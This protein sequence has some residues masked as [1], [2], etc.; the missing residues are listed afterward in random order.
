M[1]RSAPMT[2]AALCEEKL[3]GAGSCAPRSGASGGR[4]PLYQTLAA[5]RNRPL[6]RIP[7]RMLS[8]SRTRLTG[9]ATSSM[10]C[11]MAKPRP[12]WP[13]ADR[14]ARKSAAGMS[15]STPLAAAIFSRVS[16]RAA[17]PRGPTPTAVAP[18]P[19]QPGGRE[20]RH[21]NRQTAGNDELH[22][23]NGGVAAEELD[24]RRGGPE[25]QDQDKGQASRRRMGAGEE[26]T[27]HRIAPVSG[28]GRSGSGGTE[29]VAG[30]RLMAYS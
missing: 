20:R 23:G 9:P 25:A 7:S 14:T 4:G 8:P 18:P 22:P 15:T 28:R 10:A 30:H 6:I 1:V 12:N 13:W 19:G 16:L 26:R 29:A 2:A 5:L 11:T 17:S 21:Q 27:R 24:C 3:R